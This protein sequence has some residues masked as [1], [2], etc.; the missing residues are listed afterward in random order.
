MYIQSNSWYSNDDNVGRLSDKEREL[1]IEN[2]DALMRFLSRG[3]CSP[4]HSITQP[5]FGRRRK[6]DGMK[7]T[8]FESCPAAKR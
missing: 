4:Y 7:K 5:E 6:Q 2:E 3:E 1:G 8:A